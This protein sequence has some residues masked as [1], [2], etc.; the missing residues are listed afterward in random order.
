MVSILPSG[1]RL[2]LAS[3]LTAGIWALVVLTSGAAEAQVFPRPFLYGGYYS[4]P[5]AV[6][7]PR[8]PVDLGAAEILDDL[9]ERGYRSVTIAH[10]R[11]GVIV[12]DAIDP[13]RQPV[14]LVLDAYDGEILERFAR[15]GNSPRLPQDANPDARKR[16]ADRGRVAEIPMPPRR[17]SSEAVNPVAPRPAPVAPARPSSEWLPSDLAPKQ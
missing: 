6:P 11:P 10:R 14:R 16:D 5:I 12:V 2:R 17:P 9:E 8:R 3:C 1:L 7:V 4:G 15:E 13:R